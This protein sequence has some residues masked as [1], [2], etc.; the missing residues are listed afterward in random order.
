MNLIYLLIF[1]P[2]T[3]RYNKKIEEINLKENIKYHY[4]IAYN[5]AVSMIL[6]ISFWMC[7]L[8]STIFVWYGPD[9]IL[10]AGLTFNY[11]IQ[12]VPFA[13]YREFLILQYTNPLMQ[14]HT[15]SLM[16]FIDDL[17]FVVLIFFIFYWKAVLEKEKELGKD[18]I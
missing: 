2:L 8:N 5:T 14:K 7:M 18:I 1:L 9:A 16:A 10:S 6:Q 17:V 4:F 12:E 3:I 13:D 11:S 15:F